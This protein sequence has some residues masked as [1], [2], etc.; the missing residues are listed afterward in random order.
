MSSSAKELTLYDLGIY[1]SIYGLWRGDACAM[2]GRKVAERPTDYS[3]VD[4][5]VP[6]NKNV[7]VGAS[8]S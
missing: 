2:P 8:P 6:R 1:L 7:N 3:Q 5:L 4:V